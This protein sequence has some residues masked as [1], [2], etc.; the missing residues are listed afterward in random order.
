MDRHTP[1]SSPTHEA[2]LRSANERETSEHGAPFTAVCDLFLNICTY[3]NM[4]CVNTY[5]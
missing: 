2:V 3:I 4:C 1:P 5:A